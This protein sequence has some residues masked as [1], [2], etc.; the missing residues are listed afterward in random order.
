MGALVFALMM[1]AIL[2]ITSFFILISLIFLIVWI[3]KKRRGKA[4]RKRG[5][6]IPLVVL[7]VNAMIALIPIGFAAFIRHMNSQS[8][9]E[10]VYAASGKILHWTGAEG[11]LTRRFEM[12]GAEYIAFYEYSSLKAFYFNDTDDK[13][14][15]A[16][17]NIEYPPIN[18]GTVDKALMFLTTGSA[19]DEI[20]I[21][22]VYP[23]INENGF[24]FLEV[25]NSGNT[26]YCRASELDA[27][28]AYYA[29]FSNYDTQNLGCAYFVY[30]DEYYKDGSLTHVRVEKDVIMSP[31]VFEELYRMSGL[32]QEAVRVEISRRHNEPGNAG[33]QPGDIASDYYDCDLRA[34]SKDK[35]IFT[36]TPLALIDG[37]AYILRG[38]EF[39]SEGDY[40]TGYP[41]AED[42]NRY[43]IDAVF[44]KQ[45]SQQEKNASMAEYSP[46]GNPRFD[47]WIDIPSDWSAVD[48]SINGDGFVIDCGNSRVSLTAYGGFDLALGEEWYYS[49]LHESYDSVNAFVF[50]NGSNGFIAERDSRIMYGQQNKNNGSMI[51]FN[52]DHG[53]DAEWYGANQEILLRIAKSLRPGLP[54]EDVLAEDEDH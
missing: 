51:Y 32:G 23:L 35:M 26:I 37:Q 30:G 18:R 7:I 4:P 33:P 14:G 6:V 12:D 13:R 39:S 46:I 25:T 47:F 38:V 27:I 54:K 42:M 45:R 9:E 22:T 34:Y 24:S 44:T 16:V 41:L 15:E 5:L 21:S 52:I 50:D 3:V 40:I 43:I 28:D 36:E 11:E 53:G 8:A 10:V 31:D 48:N 1:A 20:K 19:E 17:A 49:R 29:D 2:L